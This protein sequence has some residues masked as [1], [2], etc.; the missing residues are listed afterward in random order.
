MEIQIGY[1]TNVHANANIERTRENLTRYALDVKRSFS[2][3]RPM[4]IGLWLSAQA[5]DELLA[6]DGVAEFS[7]WLAEN[8]LLPFTF[9]G[10]PYGDFH[11]PVVKHRVYEPTWWHPQRLD[12]T[13]KLIDIMHGVLP[14]D[15]EGSI[16]TLPL[17]WPEPALSNGQW[18]K[19]TAQLLHVA[20]RLGRLEKETGRLIHLCLEPE[21]GCIL[22]R[23]HDMV[24]LFENTLLITAGVDEQLVRRHLRVCHDICHAVVMFES[25]ADALE[26]YHKAGIEVGKVQVSSAVCVRFDDIDPVERPEAVAQLAGFAEDRYLH[27][28]M[29]R[30]SA[31]QTPRFFEDLP[32]ALDTLV[33]PECATGEW[34]VHFHVPIYL[35]KFGY[36]H[37]SRDDV[38]ACLE[39]VRQY[40]DVRHFEVETYAWDVLPLDLQYPELATGI[41]KEMAWFAE[42]LSG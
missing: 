23:S 35:E 38:H 15:S 22:Q 42:Q 14:D 41:A 5:A 34:R 40:S 39:A 20:D 31:E 13:L 11:Q 19:I 36:L 37:A 2:A 18:E 3:D 27:Q 21:P 7:D 9:N 25:Q 6:A 10:F 29:V 24:D 30:S 4:G 17:A 12:Y 26:T 16:S 8:G 28:T 1:C 32:H 33:G